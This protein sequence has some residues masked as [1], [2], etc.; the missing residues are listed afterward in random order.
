MQA[1]EDGGAGGVSGLPPGAGGHL[2]RE[3]SDEIN[4][5]LALVC[6]FELAGCIVTADALRLQ[7]TAAKEIM[8][9]DADCLFRLPTNT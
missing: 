5:A 6:Q 4:F 2:A 7:K 1:A 8:E 3:T 9:T